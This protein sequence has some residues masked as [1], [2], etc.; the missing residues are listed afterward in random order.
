MRR[1]H[2]TFPNDS[3]AESVCEVSVWSI[4]PDKPS[5]PAPLP[6][7]EGNVRVPV[8]V[9]EGSYGIVS[10]PIDDSSLVGRV[11]TR[12]MLAEMLQIKSHQVYLTKDDRG[13][14]VLDA[15]RMSFCP[16]AARLDF[17]CSHSEN[18]FAVGAAPGARIGIDLEVLRPENVLSLIPCRELAEVE[19]A[20]ILALPEGE[21]PPAFYHCW[22]AKEA[23]LKALGLGVSFGM[24]QIEIV[25]DAG[26]RHTLSK[27]SNSRQL[28]EGWSL[29]HRLVEFEEVSAIVAVVWG[30]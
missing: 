17:S 3:D 2:L 20:W 27:I 14:P 19:R 23:L 22:T 4:D 25:R 5:P 16:A 21:R 30:R 13:R 10:N 1:L 7:G 12:R 15:E 11:L 28:A 8:P 18:L 26:D 6:M 24:E 29:E 9:G